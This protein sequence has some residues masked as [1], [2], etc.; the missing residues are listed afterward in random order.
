[1]FCA[2]TMP[3]YQV[4]VYI[5]IGLLVLMMESDDYI[6]SLSLEISYHI[7]TL[8]SLGSRG[9]SMVER[10]TPV[11]E[12]QGSNPHCRRVVSLNNTH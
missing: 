6:S 1:M 11:R 3:K 12:V 10:R 5:I 9:G 7:H 4:S 2:N 8:L